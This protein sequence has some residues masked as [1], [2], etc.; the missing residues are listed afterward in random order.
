MARQ[1][2]IY[3]G[4]EISLVSLGLAKRDSLAGTDHLVVS[5]DGKG[6]T[7]VAADVTALEAAGAT[8]LTEE[9]AKT[10]MRGAAW[11]TTPTPSL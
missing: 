11:T 6:S 8:W 7:F 10:E 3:T 5:G 2:A 4:L 9:Q 1:Y